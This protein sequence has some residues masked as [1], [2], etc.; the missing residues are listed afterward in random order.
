MIAA[1]SVAGT[2]VYAQANWYAV[3]GPDGQI[4][5]TVE[6]ATVIHDRDGNAHAR[7]CLL[8]AGQCRTPLRWFFNCSDHSYSPIDT[9]ILPGF[10]HEMIVAEPGSLADRLA[11][12]ACAD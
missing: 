11:A 3:L 7:V 1:A 9:T 8:Q 10:P 12:I 4:G 6:R 5:A 2:S